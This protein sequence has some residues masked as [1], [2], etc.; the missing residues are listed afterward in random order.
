MD[1]ADNSIENA[2]KEGYKKAVCDYKP[3]VVYYQE[4]YNN[5]KKEQNINELK[6][7]TKS[8]ISG[9]VIGSVSSLLFMILLK[10]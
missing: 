5:I 9:F 6:L 8:V 4:L 2:Y 7:I 3:E 10:Y 1:E